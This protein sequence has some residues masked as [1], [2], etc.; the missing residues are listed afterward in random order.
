MLVE[1]FPWPGDAPPLLD[2]EARA[3]WHLELL[4]CFGPED[5]QLVPAW[6]Q[7]VAFGDEWA[8]GTWDD[9]DWDPDDLACTHCGG[10]GFREVDD[11]FWDDCDEFGW[12]PCTS[13][14]GTGSRSQQWV[15]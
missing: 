1:R 6:A 9:D 8:D 13:C 14:R 10:E 3:L 15:F 12:G 7:P 11:I 5:A 2:T 4:G